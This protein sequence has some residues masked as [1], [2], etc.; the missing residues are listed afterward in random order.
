MSHNGLQYTQLFNT[1]HFNACNEESPMA[2]Q[3]DTISVMLR[4]HQLSVIHKM[5]ILEQE[6]RLGLDVSGEK[7][8]SRF[9]ILGDSVGSGKS[10]MVL[11]H[12][13]NLK[14]EPIQTS[15][16]V[17]NPYSST[18]IFSLMLKEYKDISNCPALLVVPHTLYRQWQT[19]IETQTK[20]TCQYVKTKK[21]FTTKDF[22]KKLVNSDVVLISN[23]LLGDFLLF[24]DDKIW[25]S[26]T[27]FD[28]AD[29]IYISSR[30]PMPPTSFIWF[31]TAS[32]P[33]LMFENSRI[34][35]S[36]ATVSTITASPRFE[37]YDPL[38]KREMLNALVTTRGYFNRYSSRSPLY[39]STFFRIEHPYRTNIVI[40]CTDSF[41]SQS[42]T[43]PPLF[44]QVIECEPP[45]AQQ[46]VGSIL[47][48]NIQSML[49]AGDVQGVLTHLGC[50]SDSPLNIV[51]AVTE[52]RIKELERLQKTYE[53][54]SSIDYAT[55]QAKEVALKHLG[56]K[57]QSL[58]EQID[59][60]RLRIENYS[61]ETC[62]V[63]YD[64]PQES[65]VTPCCSRIFCAVCILMSLGRI[66]GCPMCRAEIQPNLLINVAAKTPQ[67]K[68]KYQDVKTGPPKKIDALMNLIQKHPNDKFLVFSRYENPF[69]PMFEKLQELN[70]KV[71]TVK[72][73]KDVINNLM[74]K[75]EKGDVRVLLLNSQHAGSGLN[76]TSATYVVLWHA[77]TSEEEKQILGRA[78]RMG[79]DKPLHFVKLLHPDEQRTQN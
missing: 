12:I 5:S 41:I 50:P 70:V 75:F 66:K 1:P 27:Y 58:K 64:E 2:P 3:S 63:C 9:G 21:S 57:I 36:H 6:L 14:K 28:E 60:I 48:T 40:K 29:T 13:A 67:K 16:P 46:I 78:Y 8:Y 23:S 53:F 15:Y 65:M 39:F 7:L 11:G 72:G 35:L 61:K 76:I 26:R 38:F 47:S 77:M 31:I 22:H 55:P 19:Y 51:E 37:S 24:L 32:W 43:L 56:E 25:F 34:W 44:T 20:L 10:L 79:R 54:K 68:S 42:I 62:P 33:N 59:T 17:L 73:N 71:E 18:N 69:R 49:N 4:S 74:T 30:Q 45:A 52:N